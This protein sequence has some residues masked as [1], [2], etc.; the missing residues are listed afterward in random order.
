MQKF[1]T[2]FAYYNHVAWG[3]GFFLQSLNVASRTLI[4][5]PLLRLKC[6]DQG[7]RLGKE[8]CQVTYVK[9]KFGLSSL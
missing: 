7:A 2:V 6:Y 5:I 3:L 1:M 8:S 9:I 4:G